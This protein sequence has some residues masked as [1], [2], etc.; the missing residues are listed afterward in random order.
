MVVPANNKKVTSWALHVFEEW[1]NQRNIADIQFTHDLLSM[2]KVHKEYSVLA[3]VVLI[4]WLVRLWVLRMY[5][6]R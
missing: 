4:R 3:S 5:K 6:G 1:R 2:H